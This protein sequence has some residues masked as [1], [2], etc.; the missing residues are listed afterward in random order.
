MKIKW[1]FLPCAGL[2]TRMGPVGKK[3]PKPLF[4][5]FDKNLLELQ[6]EYCKRLGFVHFIINIHHNV[7]LFRSWLNSKSL[8]HIIVLE[9]E[10]LLGDGGSFHNIKKNYPEIDEVF[11]FNPD[12]FLILTPEK[13]RHFFK[14]AHDWEHYLIT[15]PCNEHDLYNRFVIDGKKVV[16]RVRTK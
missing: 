3:I 14:E 8:E 12:S 16:A 10:T 11:V 2:G 6:I 15:I 5:L 4:P 7:K 13:W 9:E 1:A